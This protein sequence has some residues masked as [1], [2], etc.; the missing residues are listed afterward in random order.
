MH[1]SWLY[2]SQ[3]AGQQ[4]LSG[5]RPDQHI[6]NDDQ[7]PASHMD[8]GAMLDSY[9]T[10][11][12][13]DGAVQCDLCVCRDALLVECKCTEYVHRCMFVCGQTCC[14]KRADTQP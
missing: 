7:D 8:T 10:P 12:R 5:L 2:N 14:L 9:Q 6:G 3:G 11:H 4:Y 1:D 13:F